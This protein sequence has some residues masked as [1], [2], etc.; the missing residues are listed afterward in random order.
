MFGERACESGSLHGAW[1]FPR[2]SGTGRCGG[3]FHTRYC[4]YLIIEV[5]SNNG[6]LF[7]QRNLNW[8]GYR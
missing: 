8:C 6:L 3:F 2:S 5:L 1:R 4:I 7:G